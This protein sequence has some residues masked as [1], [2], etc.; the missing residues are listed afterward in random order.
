M[1]KPSEALIWLD[2]AGSA[3]ELTDAEKRYVDTEFSPFDGARPFIK[4]S[5]EQ[6]TPLTGLRGFLPREKLPAGVRV[7]SAPVEQ[8][9]QR[10]TPQ[11][12]AAEIMDLIGK[13][14]QK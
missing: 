6:R 13:A 8:A 5:Y 4:A 12:V 2:E 7:Q 11:G 14:R 3:R 9:P 10:K 1:P